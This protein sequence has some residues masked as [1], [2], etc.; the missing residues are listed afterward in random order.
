VF[1]PRCKYKDMVPDNLCT[2]VRPDLLESESGH[3]VRCHLTR[4]QRRTVAAEALNSAAGGGAALGG[5]APV[6]AGSAE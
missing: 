6:T 3:L 5:A 2:T 1:N 4:D